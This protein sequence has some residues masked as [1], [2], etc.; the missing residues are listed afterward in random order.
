MQTVAAISP[1]SG[2]RCMNLGGSDEWGRDYTVDAVPVPAGEVLPLWVAVVV[3]AD[4]PTGAVGGT[5]VVATSDGHSVSVSLTLH[6]MGP[7]LQNGGDDDVSRGTRIHWFDSKLGIAGDT[8]PTPYTPL[9]VSSASDGTA[10]V[11]M[12]GKR[13][14]IGADGL[15]S[16]LLV[17]TD[18]VGA[19]ALASPRQVLAEP[20]S[21][22]VD[23]L[24]DLPAPKLQMAAAS[25]MSVAWTSTQSV[26]GKGS[27]AVAGSVD[28]TGYLLINITVAAAAALPS[29]GVRL[30]LPSTPSNAFFAM[31]LG[32]PG[33]HIKSWLGQGKESD[34]KA[35]WLVFDFNETVT[36]DGF[37]CAR[38]LTTHLFS[39]GCVPH[40]RWCALQALRARRRRARRQ[41]SLPP[42][43]A[44]AGLIDLGQADCAR[45]RSEGDRRAARLLVRGDHGAGVAL[46]R[47]GRAPV[48]PV[49]A[50]H[51]LPGRCCRGG[52]PQAGRSEG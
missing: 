28:C 41:P 23:G 51:A 22:E 6:I 12:L 11:D 1:A 45:R 17:T 29:A 14:E 5:A 52:V 43:G 15:P 4:A 39:A 7:A 31:G 18:Q 38:P 42:D 34:G 49:R 16:Q 46:G 26:D 40:M 36:L 35:S 33:G 24:S 27:V 8:V 10:T 32:M 44:R 2:L 48:G 9:V 50:G 37:R 30:R 20:L 3:P 47:H 21:F 19:P 25:N 13:V